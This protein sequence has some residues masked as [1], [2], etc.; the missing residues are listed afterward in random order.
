MLLDVRAF[1]IIG[2]FWRVGDFAP[3]GQVLLGR[4][5]LKIVDPISFE[6]VGGDHQV[7]TSRLTA[8]SRNQIQVIGNTLI[9]HILAHI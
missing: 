4:P 6:G 7:Q 8:G 5:N 1:S 9:T 3:V 2:K